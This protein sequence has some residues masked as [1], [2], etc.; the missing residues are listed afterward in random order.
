MKYLYYIL[1]HS[2]HLLVFLNYIYCLISVYKTKNKSSLK[3][4]YL[5][6]F[7]VAALFTLLSTI[8]NVTISYTCAFM[9]ISFDFTFFMNR[10]DLIKKS[11]L[12]LLPILF[13]I[14]LFLVNYFSLYFTFNNILSFY[15]VIINMFILIF[16]LSHN[17][18]KIYNQDNE[19]VFWFNASYKFYA[20][21][22]ISCDLVLLFGGFGERSWTYLFIYFIIYAI[23]ITK[24]LFLLKSYKCTLSKDL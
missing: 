15:S 12:Y 13:L 1:G 3:R 19:D 4:S 11:S 7:T 21:S 9:F 20:I 2:P 17:K 22:T 10:A 6:Y 16:L 8:L 14:N 23:W 24:S 5:V 18:F